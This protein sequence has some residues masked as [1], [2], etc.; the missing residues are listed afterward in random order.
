[1][2]RRG[3]DVEEGHWFE[4]RREGVKKEEE[5]KYISQEV[6]SSEREKKGSQ[7]ALVFVFIRSSK[8]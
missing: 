1:M 4:E 5:E 7:P 8:A 3:R 6:A 2:R